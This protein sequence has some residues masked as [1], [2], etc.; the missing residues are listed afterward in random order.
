MWGLHCWKHLNGTFF[1]RGTKREVEPEIHFHQ[2]RCD[3]LNFFFFFF[4][5]LLVDCIDFLC[6]RVRGTWEES[7]FFPQTRSLFYEAKPKCHCHTIPL[8]C[9]S[10]FLN[11]RE[12][13]QLCVGVKAWI[14]PVKFVCTNMSVTFLHYF[15]GCICTKTQILFCIFF[16]NWLI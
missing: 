8:F 5:D 2:G 4:Q 12:R 13:Q 9:F 6:C 7:R 3:L 11:E 10:V 15:W 16:P 1:M 14:Q